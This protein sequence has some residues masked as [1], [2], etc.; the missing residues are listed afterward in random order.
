MDLP[1]LRALS[2]HD[3]EHAGRLVE[4]ML[5]DA[6]T[7]HYRPIEWTSAREQIVAALREAG[8][9]HSF[10]Y[11]SGRSSNEAGFLLQLLARQ[12]GTNYVNNCSYYCHQA[13]SVGLSSSI[14]GSVAT[15]R[16]E[17][18]DQADFYMLIGANPASNHP[19]LM[20]SLMQIR[21]RGGTI[22]VVN[23]VR[24]VGLM[25][26]RVPSDVRS[27]LF[28]SEIASQYV[29]PH[30]G[31]DIAFLTGIAKRVLEQHGED[32]AFIAGHTEGFDA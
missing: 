2:S 27:L 18:L 1:R 16:V 4:P 24:E 9:S 17:D 29:Q 30:I 8:P 6:R 14:G 7:N 21:R 13:S 19:R 5:L 20:R 15:G 3:L 22:V 25:N 23:P 32:S 28:G 10:F 12:F 26:F 31:G 11:A